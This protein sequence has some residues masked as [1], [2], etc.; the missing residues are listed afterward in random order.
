MDTRYYSCN[1]DR[2]QGRDG[3]GVKHASHKMMIVVVTVVSLICSDV[4]LGSFKLC[5]P[6]PSAYPSGTGLAYARTKNS[7]IGNADPI[8]APNR[9]QIRTRQQFPAHMQPGKQQIHPYP[10]AIA[11]QPELFLNNLK[12]LSP[13]YV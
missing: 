1:S 9:T 5:Q 8:F 11:E 2:C 7:S 3:D 10:I 12:L 13:L 4:N 6:F